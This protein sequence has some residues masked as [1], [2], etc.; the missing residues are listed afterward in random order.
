MTRRSLLTPFTIVLR[1]PDGPQVELSFT[2]GRPIEETSVLVSAR[3]GPYADMFERVA[4]DASWW[5]AAYWM[6]RGAWPAVGRPAAPARRAGAPERT[7]GQAPE[8][9]RRDEDGQMERG[10]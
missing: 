6:A 8:P 5:L 10:L 7:E 3:E 9:Q 2:L 1:P 4:L